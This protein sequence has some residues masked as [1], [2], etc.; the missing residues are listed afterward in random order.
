MDDPDT[1]GDGGSAAGPAARVRRPS[2]STRKTPRPPADWAAIRVAYEETDEPIARIA[3]RY[4]L[5][6]A[7]I[8]RRVHADG[9]TPRSAPTAVAQR[10]A[11]AKTRPAPDLPALVAS[12]QRTTARIVGIMEARL[13][14]EGDGVDEKDVRA[15]GA[16]AA[17]LAKVIA[18]DPQRRSPRDDDPDRPSADDDRDPWDPDVL[19]AFSRR[20]ER[21]AADDPPGAAGG[22]ERG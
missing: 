13:G 2:P 1:A 14:A 4:G 21:R 7:T 17:T 16:L 8:H 9:W 5:F 18:L 19:D 20:L 6:P 3:G 15:L 12:L 10:T 11:R 22:P